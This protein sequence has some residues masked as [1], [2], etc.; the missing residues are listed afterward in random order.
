MARKT[1]EE[2]LNEEI[3]KVLKMIDEAQTR[4]ERRKCMSELT[5]LTNNLTEIKKAKEIDHKEEKDILDY[6]LRAEQNKLRETEIKNNFDVEME[7]IQLERKRIDYDYEMKQRALSVEATKIKNDYSVGILQAVGTISSGVG[8]TALGFANIDL[9]S[10]CFHDSLEF[11]TT[12]G[13]SSQA[14]KANLN[15]ILK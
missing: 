4:E 11:E 2:L 6:Q 8:Q 13:W 1:N 10:K 15:S 14:G 9:K 3:R 7:K 12:G 5:N